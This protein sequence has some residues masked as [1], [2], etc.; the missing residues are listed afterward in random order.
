[1]IPA[2][3]LRVAV[4]SL[5]LSLSCGVFPAIGQERIVNV[6]GWTD[7][8]DPG[9]LADFTRTTGIKVT[10]ESYNSDESA[11]KTIQP[12]NAAFDVVIVSSRVLGKQIARGFYQKLDKSKLPNAVNLWPE[13][14]ERLAVYDPG[15]EHAVNYAWF[16]MGIAYDVVKARELLGNAQRVSNSSF[17]SW[18]LLFTQK[19]LKKFSTCGVGIPDSQENLLSAALQY[20]WSDWK[21]SPG[22]DR[23]TDVVRAADLLSALRRDGKR[24]D[25]SE[26]VNAL[27]DGDVCVA[28]GYSLDSLRARY[29]AGMVKKFVE[30]DF[31]IPREGAPILLDS[32]LIPTNA[33]HVE[34]AYAFI[35]FLLQPD[36]AARNTNFTGV[37]NG[38]LA[39]KTLVDGTISGNKSIYP[40]AAMMRR[41]VA[42]QFDGGAHATG[43]TISREETPT[44]G[45]ATMWGV[46]RRFSKRAK[47]PIF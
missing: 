6:Y 16:A 13:V 5:F 25:S 45:R 37:A 14:M 22:L 2:R 39:S 1:M 41:L 10:Y 17:N 38:V 11:E 31:F 44:R 33:P 29:I 9:V 3:V 19:N 20:L 43:E 40:D 21:L 35:D 8:V 12:G 24:L 30:I 4:A 18:G 47:A 34:E 46:N 27:V 32:L 42:P 23:R 15:N 7:Y 28:V 36:I 26:Y